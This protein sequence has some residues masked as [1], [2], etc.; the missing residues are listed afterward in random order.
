[1][2]DVIKEAVFTLQIQGLQLEHI[3]DLLSVLGHT[4]N[5]KNEKVRKEENYSK[6]LNE[7]LNSYFSSSKAFYKEMDDLKKLLKEANLWKTII[8]WKSWKVFFL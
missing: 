1:M 7:V 2:D 6:E 3:K 5:C 4:C 8:I